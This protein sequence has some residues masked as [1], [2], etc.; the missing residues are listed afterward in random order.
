MNRGRLIT[1]EG[2]EGAG[3]TTALATIEAWLRERGIDPVITR[4]P[5]GTPQAE[6]IR[7]ILLDPA[8]GSLA[9]ISELL[10]M[11]AA[12]NENLE[13]V[14]RPALAAGKYVVCDRFTDASLAYQGGGRQLGR[15]PVE[16]LAR[17]VHADLTPD[18]TLL[19]DVPVEI[20]LE[21]IGGRDGGPDRFEQNRPEFLERVRQA[22]LDQAERE[23]GRFQVIDA[24]ASIEEVAARI[25]VVLA[26]RLT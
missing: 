16:I 20:G 13:Q 3:K 8:T 11:F 19:L 23:P 12:R 15:E 14:I 2:G 25:R 24:G 18:L 21:R 9:P 5:G 17:L 1:L 4:E 6:R 22:Y 26:E 10:L 7:E